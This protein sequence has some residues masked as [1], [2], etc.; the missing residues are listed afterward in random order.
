MD[1]VRRRRSTRWATT[2]MPF[3]VDEVIPDELF[4]RV[5]VTD[6]AGRHRAVPRSRG[7]ACRLLLRSTS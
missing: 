1:R 7:A 3:Y 4:I 6:W 5:R 2:E